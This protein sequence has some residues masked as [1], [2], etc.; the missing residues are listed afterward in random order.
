MFL[1]SRQFQCP[2]H[3][4]RIT[5]G[6]IGALLGQEN[7]LDANTNSDIHTRISSDTQDA[8]GGCSCYDSGG[9][10]MEVL[11]SMPER[12]VAGPLEFVYTKYLGAIRTQE[13]Q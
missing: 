11:E 9:I 5:Q 3:A 7:N 6:R 4:V 2:N 8:A 10:Y 12:L 1:R 13:Q